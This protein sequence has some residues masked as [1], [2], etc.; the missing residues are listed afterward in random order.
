M[1]KAAAAGREASRSGGFSPFA[2]LGA[3]SRSRSLVTLKLARNRL[4][5]EAT[6]KPNLASCRVNPGAPLNLNEEDSIM[7]S[8][9]DFYK[10]NPQRNQGDARP[11]RA[12]RQIVAGK[13]ARRTGA[14]ARLAD[15]RL[16]VLR[17]HAHDRCAQGRRN[18][19]D[20]SPPVVVWRE[21][22]VPSPIA[23]VRRS[24]G[25]KRSRW[26]RKKHVPDAVWA[27]VKPHFSDE[28]IVD[29]T[30]LVSAIN[31]WNRFSI[32]FRKLPA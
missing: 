7:Q 17:R 18:R 27:A 25:P 13:F 6:S 20:A 3:T 22:P 24:N 9:L 21:S 11:G 10:A 32:A 8:R 29:L 2:R 30:L 5:S 15:Q 4:F 26:C 23:N 19:I 12:H 28:E 1:T 16:C 31:S 14:A